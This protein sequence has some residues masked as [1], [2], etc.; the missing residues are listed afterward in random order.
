MAS[1]FEKTQ[2]I[3][4]EV[5]IEGYDCIVRIDGDGVH[6]RRKGDRH[7]DKPTIKVPWGAVMEI[8]AEKMG[9]SAY[10]FLGFEE[11]PNATA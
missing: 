3:T 10:I 8:G 6:I 2:P 1:T 5:N 11:D 4:R 9:V 7:R